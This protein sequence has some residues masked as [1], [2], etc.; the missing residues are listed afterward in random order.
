MYNYQ[1]YHDIWNAPGSDYHELLKPFLHIFISTHS[2]DSICEI[3]CGSG[4]V[5]ETIRQVGYNGKYIGYDTNPQ[6]I[7][8]CNNTHRSKEQFTQSIETLLAQQYDLVIYSLSM[9]EMDDTTIAQY[10]ETVQS[11]QLLVVIPATTTQ[12]YPSEIYKP[13][14]NKLLA[15]L[16]K[17][18]QWIM[19][20]TITPHNKEF[21]LHYIQ[22]H[23]NT[24]ATIYNRTIGDYLNIFSQ[25]NFMFQHYWNLEYTKNTIKTAPVSKFEVLLVS[26][27]R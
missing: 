4:A 10:L 3:G 1:K 12:Y 17:T 19:K 13:F 15:R 20:S 25:K 23:A 9:C 18:P 11:K 8:F 14:L 27:T 21:Y 2:V 5:L 16:G 7:E 24:T 6:A 26:K 22:S